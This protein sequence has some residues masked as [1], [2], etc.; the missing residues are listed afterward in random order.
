MNLK[1]LI[2]NCPELEGVFGGFHDRLT[3]LENSQPLNPEIKEAP[4]PKM[5]PEHRLFDRLQQLEGRFIHLE[6]KVNEKRDAERK[7]TKNVL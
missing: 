4:L 6:N 1:E 7:V 3:E 2:K 5:P